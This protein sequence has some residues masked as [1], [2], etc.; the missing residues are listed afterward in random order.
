MLKN[1]QNNKIVFIGLILLIIGIII[2]IISIFIFII[3]LIILLL[4]GYSVY[5]YNKNGIFVN[6]YNKQTLTNIIKYNNYS[7]KEAYLIK[8]PLSTLLIKLINFI[9]FFK[10]NDFFK[11]N[12]ILHTYII[13]VIKKKK[14]IKFLLI[15]KTFNININDNINLPKIHN[16]IKIPIHSN[17]YKLNDLLKKIKNESQENYGWDLNNNCQELSKKIIDFLKKNNK[18]YF[19]Q[20]KIKNIEF[21]KFDVYMILFFSSLL[22]IITNQYHTFIYNYFSL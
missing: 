14:H 22:N 20:Y 6:N 4:L 11:N 9:T 17:K 12:K 7:I 5:N 1:I 19:F 13:L 16:I 18:E 10:Y 3:I 8:S 2:F 21:Q 15:D